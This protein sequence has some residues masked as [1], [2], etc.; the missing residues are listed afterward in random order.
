MPIL[1]QAQFAGM[2]PQRGTMCLL[3]TA[4]SWDSGR[5][6][7]GSMSHTCRENPLRRRG[8]L[9]AV[10]GIEYAAQ[11]MA[12]HGALESRQREGLPTAEGSPSPDGS[13]SAMAG[14]IA[15]VRD[16]VLQVARLDDIPDRLVVTAMQLVAQ[17]RHLLYEFTV[18]AGGR[19]LLAGRIAVALGMGG[20]V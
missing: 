8:Q 5:I 2:L 6:V 19:M 7:C 11:A 16:V 10:A 20:S 4:D 1:T 12:L 13:P 9:P 15:S 3:E 18:Q 17:Q 14:M